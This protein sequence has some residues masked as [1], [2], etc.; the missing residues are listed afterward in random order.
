MKPARRKRKAG[1]S[2]ATHDRRAPRQDEASSLSVVV[3]G[4]ELGNSREQR[5]LSLIARVRLRID[6]SRERRAYLLFVAIGFAQDGALLAIGDSRISRSGVA[7]MATLTLWLG[8]RSRTAW[9]LFVAGNT[10]LLMAT[11]ALLVPFGGDVM[12]GDVITLVLGCST[13][14]AI[15]LSRPMRTWIKSA[16][17]AELPAS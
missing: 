6:V 12:W 5:L 8:R 2:A 4:T 13:L 11:L 15:L 17:V 16:S 14:L 3:K 7:L 1:V 9:W 10:Y